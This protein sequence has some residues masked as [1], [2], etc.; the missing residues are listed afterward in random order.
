MIDKASE[1]P[2]IFSIYPRIKT[3]N[4]YN[5]KYEI[6]KNMGVIG[7]LN[8]S[9]R[10]F[11]NIF[12]VYQSLVKFMVI[13][14]CLSLV[15]FFYRYYILGFNI[16]QH[17]KLRTTKSKLINKKIGLYISVGENRI[18]VNFTRGMFLHSGDW[19]DESKILNIANSWCKNKNCI[20]ILISFVNI[21]HVKS[22]KKEKKLR[23]LRREINK[24]DWFTFYFLYNF[25]FLETRDG[26]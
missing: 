12:M 7:N 10:Y 2:R 8:L 11:F 5:R 9:H 23:H 19:Y 16:L 3:I 6:A 15:I 1:I 24:K 20:R 22:K 14:L 26:R 13:F 25:L 18:R 17:Q 21:L 4:D